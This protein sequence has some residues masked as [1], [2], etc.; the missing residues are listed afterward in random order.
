MT[1]DEVCA[2]IRPLAVDQKTE[3]AKSVFVTTDA[4]EIQVFE[5]GDAVQVDVMRFAGGIHV[6]A[7]ITAEAVLARVREIA[8]DTAPCS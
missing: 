4:N 1:K 5:D 8:P 7:G 6:D 3:G 2:L